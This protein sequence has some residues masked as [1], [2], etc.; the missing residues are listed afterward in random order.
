[1]AVRV[2]PRCLGCGAPRPLEA[3]QQEHTG[4]IRIQTIGGRGRCTWDTQPLDAE[5]A[6]VLYRR[7]KAAAQ[8]LAEGLA[9]AGVDVEAVA[10]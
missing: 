10:A 5:T 7:F 9:A 1:M 2:L 3:F 6:L 4:E 8:E